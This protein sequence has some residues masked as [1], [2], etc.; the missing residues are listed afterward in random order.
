MTSLLRSVSDGY[1]IPSGLVASG[2]VRPPSSKSLTQ[3]AFNLSLLAKRPCVISR[4][5]ISEDT[6]LYLAAL[7]RLGYRWTRDRDRLS[8]HP[9]KLTSGGRIGCGL[10]GTM[11]RF[12]TAALSTVPGEWILDGSERLR[13]RPIG[14][15]VE[16]LR[17]LGA[18]IRY[19]AREGFAPISVLGGALG[20]GRVELDAS[21][22]SQF[23]SAILMAAT[24]AQDAVEVKVG[25]VAS[26]PYVELTREVMS[27]F[28]AVC[29]HDSQAG[30]YRV[31][32]I[33]LAGVDFEVEGDFSSAAYAAAAAIVTGGSVWIEGLRRN[34]RQ[35]DRRFL[36][37]LGE[38]GAGL[39][40]RDEGVE[41]R[42]GT[43]WQGIEIDLSEMPDQVPTIAVLAP[44]ARGETLVKNVG[45]LRLKE[46]DRLAAMVTEL[47]RLGASIK[48]TADGLEIEGTWADRGAIPTA[49]VTVET[50]G[51]HRV[52][53]SLAICGL[54]RPGVTVGAPGVVAKS[55]PSFWADFENLLL[56]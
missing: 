20:G 18:D 38:M 3:R 25:T 28:G 41:V 31:E 36:D 48:E 9:G 39:T 12:L 26:G 10:N 54:A 55:Y 50:Y 32:P 37:V 5:L 23:L 6:D 16:A 8:I 21:Q 51:D 22:S 13:K 46:S 2:R 40:W 52:A 44:F 56:E 1:E 11:L 53:M 19:G 15:L 47:D 43:R 35:G 24:Q 42:A 29:V 45:H 49:A 33:A 27:A 14:P 30:T 4:P 7:E 17:S 34:S